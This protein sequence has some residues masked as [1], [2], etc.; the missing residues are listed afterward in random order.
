[1]LAPG[2]LSQAYQERDLE[3]RRIALRAICEFLDS[4]LKLMGWCGPQFGG[5]TRSG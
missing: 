1:M 5:P 3:D 2:G 4:R